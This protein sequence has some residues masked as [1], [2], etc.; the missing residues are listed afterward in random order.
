MKFIEASK[1]YFDQAAKALDLGER[2]KRQLSTPQREIKVELTVPLDSGEIAT[3]VGYRVQHD[4]SRGPMKGG[5]RY[6]PCVDE[7][8]VTALAS[9]MT[10]K[11][12]VVDLPYG[13]AKGGVNCDPRQL[14]QNELQRLTR[15]LTDRMQDVIGPYRDIPAPDMGTNAQTMAWIVDQYS[16]YHGW[17]PAVITGKPVELGGSLGREAATGRGCLYALEA[18][19]AD[20]RRSIEGITVAV[21]GF[22]NVGSWAARLMAEQGARIVAVSDVTGATYNADGLDMA[23]LVEHVQKT[24]GVINFKGG[25]VLK[26]EE[27][28]TCPC[29]VLVPAALE[30]QLTEVN[31][32]DVQAKIIVEGAN[33][34]T[35]P[36]A[37]ETFRR[38][39]ITVIPDIFANAGGVT[40][41][42]FEWVQNIQQYRWSEERVNQELRAR[43]TQAWADLKGA[44]KN[45]RDLREAAFMLAVSRVAKATLLRS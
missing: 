23:A 37:D 24:R 44:A 25:E 39:G 13:G 3:F 21:Q 31:A 38:R 43:M 12:A 15:V 17:S 1:H 10:W 20:Q 11:T 19:L 9:L 26:A 40:V 41:S 42:Y 30:E 5:I 34:P 22:G 2:L 35:T 14:S 33:G 8:E 6:H 27:I 18:L 7:D 36:E 45:A 32:K 29:E 28:L 16:N 4:S